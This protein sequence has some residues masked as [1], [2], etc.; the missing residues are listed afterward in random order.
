MLLIDAGNTRIK[1]AQLEGRV[2]AR[3]RAAVHAG[4]SERDYARA[5]FGRSPPSSMLVSSVAGELVKRA[6]TAA[7][8][9]AGVRIRFVRVPQRAAGVTVGYPEPW[10]LG[11]D[12]FVG[13]VG[14][15][16]LLPRLAVCVVGVGT[17]LTVD[18]VD[19]A[20]RHRGGAI[21]PS[22]SLMVDTLLS[23]TY[24]IRRR[25]QG[26]KAGATGLFAR[27]TRDGIAQGSLYAAAA[28]IDRAAREAAL[29]LDAGRPLVVLTGGGATAVR[30][31]IESAAIS[32]PDLVLKGLA[33]LAQGREGKDGD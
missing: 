1:W 32:V 25:A 29:A 22:P 24:G 12:R 4:F 11:V 7:A 23:R 10:R 9:R 17:A 18:L 14:A 2:L 26:G 20:G 5:L 16:H 6:L 15:V 3:A 27:S 33:V 13:L 19:A 8:R 21:V 30:P 28:L 31:L